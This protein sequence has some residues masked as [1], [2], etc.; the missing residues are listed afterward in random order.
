MAMKV[1]TAAAVLSTCSVWAD[2]PPKD[3]ETC[4]AAKVGAKCKT[5]DQKVGTCVKTICSRNDYSDGPPP[6]VVAVECLVC[7]TP[8][9]GGT[10]R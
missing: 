10:K 1:L 6:K 4:R 5:D 2:I 7:A 9:D 8:A 3:S